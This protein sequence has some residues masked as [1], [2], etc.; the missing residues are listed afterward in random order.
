LYELLNDGDEI[1]VHGMLLPDAVFCLKTV[2]CGII[3]VGIAKYIYS[4]VAE[5][6]IDTVVFIMDV[7]NDVPVKPVI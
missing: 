3:V 6:P 2:G 7:T 5:V 4:G 1:S